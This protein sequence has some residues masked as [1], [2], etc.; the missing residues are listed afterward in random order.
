MGKCNRI[1][2]QYNKLSYNYNNNNYQELVT[3]HQV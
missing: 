2:N 1:D 3:L